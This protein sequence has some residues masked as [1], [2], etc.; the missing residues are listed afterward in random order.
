MKNTMNHKIQ[1]IEQL[2]ISLLDKDD[3]DE[4]VLAFNNIGWNKPRS[5]YGKYIKEQNTNFRTIF[6]AKIE[7][8]FCGYATIKW[9]SD[10]QLFSLNN[11]PE[12]SDLN[13]LPEFRKK[14]IGTALIQHCESTAK[15]RGH[16]EIGLGVGMTR[17]YGSAQRLYVQLGYLPDGNGLHYKYK[18]AN[19]SE[20]VIVDD[21]LNL[22]LKK[23]L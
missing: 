9:K 1:A 5:I 10:Y 17:D 11:I 12:I 13:V 7:E 16:A 23:Q 19:Y 15:T 18:T 4:I 8:K 14:G 21:D 2:E 3:I 22:Y 20:T 6:I